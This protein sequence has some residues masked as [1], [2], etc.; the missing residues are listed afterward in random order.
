MLFPNTT[1]PE[2]DWRIQQLKNRN[3]NNQDED[4]SPSRININYLGDADIKG[5]HLDKQ[6]LGQYSGYSTI[7]QP[8]SIRTVIKENPAVSIIATFQTNCS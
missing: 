5:A 3:Y 6:I 7:I 1:A 4:P 2:K 8:F